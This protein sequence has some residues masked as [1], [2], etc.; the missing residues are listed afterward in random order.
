MNNCGLG[1]LRQPSLVKASFG[2][3]SQARDLQLQV[4]SWLTQLSRRL[5][6]L[7]DGC[8]ISPDGLLEAHL[9]QTF[10][11]MVGKTDLISVV[12]C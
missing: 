2:A 10:V 11:D 5:G 1:R 12:G 4:G 7:E 8:K 9:E 3:L 6:S